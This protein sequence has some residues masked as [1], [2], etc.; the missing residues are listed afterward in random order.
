MLYTA[1]EGGAGGGDGV[2][3]D[4]MWM[5]NEG[6]GS[7]YILYT[8]LLSRSLS[9]RVSTVRPLSLTAYRC[10]RWVTGYTPAFSKE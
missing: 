8:P 2:R 9:S 10:E 5:R 3:L 1:A 6:G 7:L 4:R